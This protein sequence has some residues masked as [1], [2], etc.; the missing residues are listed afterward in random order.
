LDHSPTT[1]GQQA[2]TARERDITLTDVARAAVESTQGANNKVILEI[3]RRHR[4]EGMERP[5]ISFYPCGLAGGIANYTSIL[6]Q[7]RLPRRPVF[8]RLHSRCN[9]SL[10]GA[11]PMISISDNAIA[12]PLPTLPWL[13]L[14]Q[15]SHAM[16]E[17]A[18]A[19]T[20]IRNDL[21]R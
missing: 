11:M 21:A 7:M 13:G 12:L 9:I 4:D 14:D 2:L 16:G 3:V 5:E 20:M 19:A 15:I 18:V 6:A 10:P 8:V 1:E 17:G